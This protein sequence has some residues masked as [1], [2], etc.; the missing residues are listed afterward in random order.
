[1]LF[2]VSRSLVLCTTTRATR[3]TE[4]RAFKVDFYTRSG[5][6]ERAHPRGRR[7]RKEK[8]V[9]TDEDADGGGGV[10][11]SSED[12]GGGG[13]MAAT[14]LGLEK[15]DGG[16]FDYNEKIPI[17]SSQFRFKDYWIRPVGGVSN[18]A[19]PFNFSLTRPPSP[20]TS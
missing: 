4:F 14:G 10:P 13:K 19:G 5:E 3:L 16:A 11:G 6:V 18:Q 20:T 12:S 17:E 9:G 2:L 7:R 15:Y 8:N 1:M